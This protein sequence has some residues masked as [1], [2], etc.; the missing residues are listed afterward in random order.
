[1]I[2]ASPLITPDLIASAMTY[3]QYVQLSTDRYANGLST[4]DDPHY[5]T[6]EILGYTKLNLHRMSRLSKLTVVRPELQQALAQVTEPWTWLV[7][8]ESWC[9]DAAQIIPVLDRIAE[10]SPNITF[11][12]LLRDQNPDLMNAYLTNGGRSIPKLICLHSET[13]TEVGT[14]GPRP[15]GLQAQMNE[16]RSEKLSLDEAVERAQR[17]YNADQTQ[18]TQAELLAAVTSWS[19]ISV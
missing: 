17:W 2:T 19:K 15:A 1:M 8:T 4:S 5:N 12:L 14:W 13:L 10:T 9:G 7:L 18:S 16:W 3:E 11:R 6:P